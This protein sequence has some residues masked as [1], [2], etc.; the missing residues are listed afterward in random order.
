MLHHASEKAISL[1][2]G[3]HRIAWR[4]VILAENPKVTEADQRWAY[5]DDRRSTFW[6]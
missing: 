4:Y 5:Q 2:R 6:D 1:L 3:A